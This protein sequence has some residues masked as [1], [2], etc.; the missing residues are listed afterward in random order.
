MPAALARLHGCF[1]LHAGWAMCEQR[2][3]LEC[4]AVTLT[5]RYALSLPIPATAESRHAAPRGADQPPPA[6]RH[7]HH[8]HHLEP[9]LHSDHA[10][11]LQLSACCAVAWVLARA[12]G[13]SGRGEPPR[14][15]ADAVL[16]PGRRSCPPAVPPMLQKNYNLLAV[17]AFMAITGI[18]Q[19]Q[20]KIRWDMEHKEGKEAA[21]AQK[22]A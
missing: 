17:N 14:T 18:Y 3:G 2:R 4:C 10:G 5:R 9:L 13:S 11:E 6:V 22:A 8:R 7:H 19:L 21:A 1:A 16:T 20:R 12:L 15:P